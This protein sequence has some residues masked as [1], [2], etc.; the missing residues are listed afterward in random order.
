M[1]PVG[2]AVER[3]GGH[4]VVD[5]RVVLQRPSPG[6]EHAEEAGGIPAKPGVLG[7]EACQ[8]RRRGFEE[9]VVTN[10]LMVERERKENAGMVKVIIKWGTGSSRSIRLCNQA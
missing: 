9:C 8:Y 3:P 7:S 6:M 5:V 1:L 10:P 2:L 4:D